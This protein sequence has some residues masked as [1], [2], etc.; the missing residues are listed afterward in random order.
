M[1]LVSMNTPSKTKGLGGAQASEL[2]WVEE[3]A[4]MVERKGQGHTVLVEK[5][6]LPLQTTVVIQSILAN[7]TEIPDLEARRRR[8]LIG[9][10]DPEAV[11]ALFAI[12]GSWV[13]AERILNR[14]L[15]ISEL[16]KLT[17]KN[18]LAQRITSINDIAAAVRP[19]LPTFSI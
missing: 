16:S 6:T 3:N 9:G 2:K 14:N 19:T 1:M 7:G 17:S 15:C 5:R 4:C 18:F 8:V 13:P 11:A 10:Q 12:N